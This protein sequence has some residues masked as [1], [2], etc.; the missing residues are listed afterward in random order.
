MIAIAKLVD[1]TLHQSIVAACGNR[2]F[3]FKCVLLNAKHVSVQL[4]Q[5]IKSNDIDTHDQISKFTVPHHLQ[6][7]FVYNSTFSD[8]KRCRPNFKRLQFSCNAPCFSQKQILT[9]SNLHFFIRKSPLVFTSKWKGSNNFYRH[10]QQPLELGEK[11]NSFEKIC[12]WQ[13]CNCI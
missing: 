5:I 13:N 2:S 3:L 10:H 7:A 11:C 12:R 9:F 6:Q 1:F 4:G 8:E